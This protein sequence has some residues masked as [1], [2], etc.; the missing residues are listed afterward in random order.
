MT[1]LDT[2]EPDVPHFR[3]RG[4]KP[5]SELRYP[6]EAFGDTTRERNVDAKRRP[7]D[8]VGPSGRTRRDK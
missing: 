8:S 3:A 6:D 7:E 2:Q 1:R 5:L 4:K